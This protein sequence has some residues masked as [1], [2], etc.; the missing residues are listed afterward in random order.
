MARLV[1]RPSVIIIARTALRNSAFSLT[2]SETMWR[3]PSSASSARHA[4]LS[5][6]FG[7][8]RRVRLFPQEERERFEA[9]V[10][11]DRGFGAPFGL[12]GQVE[13]FELGFFER[14]KDFRFEFGGEFALFLDRGEHGFATVF[15]FAEVLEFFLNVADLDFVQVAGD[16]LAIAGNEGYGSALVEQ[17]DDGDIPFRGTFSSL[18][19]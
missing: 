14:G 5:G 13:I 2:I 12:V 10:A 1:T 17:R 9:L 7:E 8:R 16:F 4:E 6:D 11:G 15:Q 18:A 19:M 3:A